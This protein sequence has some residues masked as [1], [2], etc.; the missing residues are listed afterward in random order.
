MTHVEAVER[1][2]KQSYEVKTAPICHATVNTGTGTPS[3][4]HARKACGR[5][6]SIVTTLPSSQDYSLPVLSASDSDNTPS[7][8]SKKK[9]KSVSKLTVGTRA[10]CKHAHRDSS[11]FWGI[12]Q[13]S[14]DK[15]NELALAKITELLDRCRWINV[16]R[17]TGTP[18]GITIVEIRNE[19]GGGHIQ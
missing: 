8:T 11:G 6:V 18:E 5:A 14:E 19:E 15:K 12:C 16:H 1:E 4:K 17:M 2:S 3:K 13:G 9:F 10:L 7:V